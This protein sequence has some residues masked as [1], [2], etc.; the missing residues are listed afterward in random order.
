MIAPVGEMRAMLPPVE[1]VNH[2]EPSDPAGAISSEPSSAGIS[3]GTWEGP[4]LELPPQ[5]SEK[6]QDRRSAG[7]EITT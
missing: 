3:S 6:L 1:R 2:I 5:G 4:T 7:F